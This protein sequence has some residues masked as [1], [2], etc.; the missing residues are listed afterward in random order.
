[1]FAVLPTG[2]GKSLC[3][4]CLPFT[5]EELELGGEGCYSIDSYNERPGK[6]YSELAS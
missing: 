4:A 2:F 5:F 3:Y 1:M 6:C